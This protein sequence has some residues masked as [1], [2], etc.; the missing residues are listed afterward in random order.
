MGDNQPYGQEEPKLETDPCPVFALVESRT[1][2]VRCKLLLEC[3]LRGSGHGRAAGVPSHFDRVG[4]AAG[5]RA[6]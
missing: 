4:S 2:V 3:T 6:A 1:P 5:S